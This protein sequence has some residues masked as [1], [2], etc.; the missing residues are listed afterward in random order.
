MKQMAFAAANDSPPYGTQMLIKNLLAKNICGAIL[1]AT[2]CCNSVAPT[3]FRYNLHFRF[4]RDSSLKALSAF[5]PSVPG[6]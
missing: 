6:A 2:H 3:S 1:R 5:Q 4:E